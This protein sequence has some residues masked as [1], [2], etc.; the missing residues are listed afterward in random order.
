MFYAWSR[1][2]LCAVALSSSS[3]A[4]QAAFSVVMI[5]QGDGSYVAS[6]HANARSVTA[7]KQLA[8]AACAQYRLANRLSGKCTVLFW[9][10]GPGYV[11]V[12]NT[13][14]GRPAFAGAA[15]GASPQ[16]AVNQA[17][18]ACRNGSQYECKDTAEWVVWD[19]GHQGL[20]EPQMTSAIQSVRKVVVR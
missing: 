20:P 4:A 14:P 8:T 3:L 17:Y 2:I 11:A 18:A 15:L 5:P 12:V 1:Q 16:E 10:T 9:G 6:V 19:G 7:A 13:V